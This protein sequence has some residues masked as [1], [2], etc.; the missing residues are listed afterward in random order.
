MRVS[1]RTHPVAFRY[2]ATK[3]FAPS[4]SASPVDLPEIGPI[5]DHLV[6]DSNDDYLYLLIPTLLN[7]VR[8][9]I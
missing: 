7:V 5:L 3:G 8:S 6:S 4:G 9:L 1:S 2:L